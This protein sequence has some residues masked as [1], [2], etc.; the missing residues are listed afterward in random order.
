VQATPAQFGVLRLFDG[1]RSID[2]VVQ[3]SHSPDLETLGHIAR[4][5][6]GGLLELTPEP[7]VSDDSLEGSTHA[8][9]FL[10]FAAS[11]GV[12][13]SPRR[14]RR[15]ASGVA[16]LGATTLGAVLGLRFLAERAPPSPAAAS[17]APGAVTQTTGAARA[18]APPV[19]VAA[20]CE[21][22]T[23]L[24]PGDAGTP[25]FCLGRREVTVSEYAGCV[26]AGSCT[27]PS[28]PDLAV[29]AL[30]PELR[31]RS[32]RALAALCNA[33]NA[34]RG[35]HPINCVTQPQARAYCAFRGGRLPTEAEWEL[36][37]R[38]AD[39]RQYP[40]GNA[41]PD[42][43][44]LNACGAE[45]E[46]WY[47]EA[48]LGT[49]FEGLMY[50]GDDGYAATAPGGSFPRGTSGEGVDDLLGNVAEWTATRVDFFDADAERGALEGRAP[51][52]FVVRG[53]SFSSG[54]DALA[55]PRFRMNL[56]ADRASESVGFRCAFSS[57]S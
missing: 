4:L 42:S 21:A 25:A 55:A 54:A 20:R 30:T 37:L 46:S 44:R 3:A 28:K 14:Q 15:F 13:A 17:S 50:D 29:S 18:G 49:S 36:A 19:L 24:I 2:Q 47:S 53:G 27:P 6:D 31:R 40:W 43:A 9:S 57:G 35:E 23:A 38:G 34:E 22:A 51:A 32:A 48:G 7:A 10:P 12:P 1:R 56:G 26:G 45:C 16:A 41:P 39:G 33:T 5:L 52:S 8:L 11:L